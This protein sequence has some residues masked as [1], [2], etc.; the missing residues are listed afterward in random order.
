MLLFGHRPFYVAVNV[1]GAPEGHLV[2]SAA[3]K[4]IFGVHVLYPPFSL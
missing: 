1:G 3:I 4:L 2:L